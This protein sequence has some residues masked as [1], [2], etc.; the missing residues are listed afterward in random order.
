MNTNIFIAKTLWSRGSEKNGLG[1]GSTLIATVSVAVSVMVMVLAVSISDG[2]KK[3]I[4]MKA[5]G[6]SGEILLHAPGAEYTTSQYPIQKDIQFLDVIKKHPSIKA[7]QPYAYRSGIIKKDDE[8]QG[9]VVKGVDESYNWDYFNSVIYE[10]RAP[11]VSDSLKKGEVLISL[12]LANMLDYSV[13]DDIVLYFINQNVK[14]R[15]FTVCGIYS[16]QLEDIDKTFIIGSLSDIQSINDWNE[17]EISGIELLLKKGANIDKTAEEIEWIIAGEENETSFYVTKVRE[18]YPHL[19]DWLSLL[20]LN[21]LVVLILMLSVAGFNMISGLLI[22][23]FEKISM[24]GLLK[25][26]GMKDSGIHKVFLVRTLYLV[27]IGAVSGNIVAVTLAMIQKKWGVITLDPVNY[28]VNQVPIYLNP[29]KLIIMN[30]IA[31]VIISV[32]LMIPS[33]FISKVSPEKTLRVK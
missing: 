7:L 32:L 16:A 26:L 24:I 1:K 31:F 11:A 14:V 23:L 5:S 3:E 18:L 22:L 33:F 13:G 8:I 17:N 19:F 29:T 21:V 6:F 20:D 9:V 27:L 12:R 10:G 25:S 15:K 2:F 4:Q 28:F 30:V